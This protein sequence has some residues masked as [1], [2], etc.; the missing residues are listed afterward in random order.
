MV[1]Q[2]NQL[3]D[4]GQITWPPGEKKAPTPKPTPKKLGKTYL[5]Q[6]RQAK[7]TAQKPLDQLSL[8][9][10]TA[11]FTQFAEIARREGILALEE[12][13]SDKSDH[14][15]RSGVRLAVDG[16]EPDLIIDILETWMESLLHEKK[17][18][19]QKVIEAIMAIQSGDNPRIVEHKLS[20]LY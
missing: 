4:R 2:V 10:L 6:K 8:N 12:M 1:Q 13:V 3:V 19:Y 11:L 20:V 14:Y 7:Q 5:A 16:T 15:V 9:D 17:R 18:K